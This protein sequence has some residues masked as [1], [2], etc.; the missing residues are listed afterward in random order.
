MYAFKKKC[1]Q[2]DEW[3]TQDECNSLCEWDIHKST[4]LMARDVKV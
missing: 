1:T 3:I 4:R 2:V